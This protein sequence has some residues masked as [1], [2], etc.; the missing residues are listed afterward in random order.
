MLGRFCHGDELFERHVAEHL[1]AEESLQPEAIFA[2]VVHLP[3]GRVGNVLLRPVLRG[4][5]I[6]YLGL[7]GAASEKQIPITD[8]RV[9]VVG[10]RIVLRLRE[11]RSRDHPE[12]FQRP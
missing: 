10:D 4:Y 11:P 8:L 7:S 12:A 2:E 1:R 6:P 3:E 5:E 9:S